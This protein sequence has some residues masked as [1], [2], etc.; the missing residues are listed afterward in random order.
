MVI[1]LNNSDTSYMI[2]I[3]LKCLLS[4]DGSMSRTHLIAVFLWNVTGT[5]FLFQNLIFSC[6]KSVPLMS[7]LVFELCT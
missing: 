7:K 3:V 6:M 1:R 4:L 2:F 5:S